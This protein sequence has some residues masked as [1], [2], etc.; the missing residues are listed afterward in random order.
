MASQNRIKV[1]QIE[2]ARIYNSDTD[3]LLFHPIIVT[4]KKKVS[5]MI[6]LKHKICMKKT[7]Y[8]SYVRGYKR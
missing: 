5:K 1:K 3:I 2:T 8:N 6:D 7:S 4:T